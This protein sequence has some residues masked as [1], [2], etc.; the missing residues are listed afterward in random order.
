VLAETFPAA[1]G[2][3]LA[4]CPGGPRRMGLTWLRGQDEQQARTAVPHSDLAGGP[5]RPGLSFSSPTRPRRDPGFPDGCC[6][7]APGAEGR[8]SRRTRRGRR[9]SRSPDGLAGGPTAARRGLTRRRTGRRTRARFSSDLAKTWPRAGAGSRAPCPNGRGIRRR[10]EAKHPPGWACPPGDSPAPRGHQTPAHPAG[11]GNRP[12][13]C[14]SRPARP[15]P[16]R[17]G[18][19]PQTWKGRRPGARS[20]HDPVAGTQAR[21]AVLETS[22]GL[23]NKLRVAIPAD[24]SWGPTGRRRRQTPRAAGEHSARHASD[25]CPDPRPDFGAPPSRGHG[26]PDSAVPGRR[27][28]RATT[29]GEIVGWK[30]GSPPLPPSQGP[31]DLIEA[32]S[33][34]PN[35]LESR[36]RGARGVQSCTPVPP[37]EPVARGPDPK[38]G[39]DAADSLLRSL[40]GPLEDT[41]FQGLAKKSH[42]EI[43]WARLTLACRQALCDGHVA[44][45]RARPARPPVTIFPTVGLGRAA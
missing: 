24:G 25:P 39:P 44:G 19:G 42:T 40:R 38:Q 37:T 5:R 16:P 33:F 27:P 43:L 34:P 10:T 4:R 15:S 2:R 20:N 31:H 36:H 22:P 9:W 8:A 26:R 6:G 1:D 23:L 14:R 17:T 11:G 45:H 30:Q 21:G 28:S 3:R 13:G 32:N 41:Q 29:A 12:V 18:P 7:R 35:P